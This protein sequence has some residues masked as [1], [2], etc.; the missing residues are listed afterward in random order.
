MV[1]TSE[2]MLAGG[3]E[4][5]FVDGPEHD[6]LGYEADDKANP[7]EHSLLAQTDNLHKSNIISIVRKKDKIQ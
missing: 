2:R 4:D 3:G 7:K 1:K 5:V 6:E